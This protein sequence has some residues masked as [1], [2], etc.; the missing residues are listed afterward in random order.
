MKNYYVN[1]V[2]YD[3]N[4]QIGRKTLYINYTDFYVICYVMFLCYIARYK[5][6]LLVLRAYYNCYRYCPTLSDFTR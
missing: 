4:V 3:K 5:I 6:T 1:Y 2:K